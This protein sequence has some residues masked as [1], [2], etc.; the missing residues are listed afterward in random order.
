ME[1]VSKLASA[2]KTCL[3]NVGLGDLSVR[4]VLDAV[5][6]AYRTCAADVPDAPALEMPTFSDALYGIKFG[7]L[8]VAWMFAQCVM[9]L[10]YDWDLRANLRDE[11]PD[12]VHALTSVR[13]VPAGSATHID[14]LAK[15]LS[16]SPEWAGKWSANAGSSRFT[17]ELGGTRQEI[18]VRDDDRAK[19]LLR[20]FMLRAYTAQRESADSEWME[21]WGQGV[22]T[23][24]DCVLDKPRNLKHR[25]NTCYLAS[26]IQVVRCLQL[27]GSEWEEIASGIQRSAQDAQ[28]ELKSFLI[29]ID[30]DK[31]KDAFDKA[32]TTAYVDNREQALALRD[33]VLRAAHKNMAE[34][35]NEQSRVGYQKDID[36]EKKRIELIN[37]LAFDKPMRT[38]VVDAFRIAC[39]GFDAGEVHRWVQERLADSI[40]QEQLSQR[41]TQSVINTWVKSEEGIRRLKA[42]IPSYDKSVHGLIVKNPLESTEQFKRFNTIPIHVQTLVEHPTMLER[43]RQIKRVTVCSCDDTDDFDIDFMKLRDYGFETDKKYNLGSQQDAQETL[44]VIIGQLLTHAGYGGCP[45]MGD[46]NWVQADWVPKDKDDPWDVQ[47]GIEAYEKRN[48]RPAVVR[49][50]ALSYATPDVAFVSKIK[51]HTE[52]TVFDTR[53]DLAAIIVHK[54]DLANPKGGHY[55]CYCK[56]AGAWFECD[57]IK[58]DVTGPYQETIRDGA[59]TSLTMNQGGKLTTIAFPDPDPIMSQVSLLMYRHP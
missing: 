11:I 44:N 23:F 8:E 18:D 5:A 50:H 28:R 34:A 56:Y 6:A 21:V 53:L 1:R 57:D 29:E 25:G 40:T 9:Y 22:T 7:S 36:T 45:P 51:L 37:K 24:K 41:I 42:S 47:S 54:G 19:V 35:P 3:P 59:L 52:I 14:E 32:L 43:A 30:K 12:A 49:G 16:A 39:D 31:L 26:A 2:R 27:S 46:S 20:A 33:F 15:A 13:V 48:V 58:K 10:M 38:A 17:V 4:A 55:I